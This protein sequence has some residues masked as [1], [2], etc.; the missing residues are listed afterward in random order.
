MNSTTNDRAFE[1]DAAEG[2]AWTMPTCSGVA[3]S[4]ALVF[5]GSTTAE[6]TNFRIQGVQ[7]STASATFSEELRT[8][9][10]HH[11][12]V[13]DASVDDRADEVLA[14]RALRGTGAPTRKLGRP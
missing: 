10:I 2:K 6:A 5:S 9:A 3:L 4:A 12:R 8:W 1:G 11:A 13:L 14:R 7:A